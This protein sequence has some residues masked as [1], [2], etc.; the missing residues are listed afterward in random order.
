MLDSNVKINSK[1]RYKEYKAADTI[2]YSV[3][4][5][6]KSVFRSLLT[7]RSFRFS[8]VLRRYE[9]IHNCKK[10]IFA[11]L[12]E[13][14]VTLYFRH[15]SVKLCYNVPINVLGPGCCLHAYGPILINRGASVGDNTRIHVGVHLG[16]GAGHA[17]EAPKI[18]ANCYLGPGVK[19]FGNITILDGTAVG[20]NAVVNKGCEKPNVLLVGIPAVVKKEGIDTSDYVVPATI[21]AK[22][23]KA[24]QIKLHHKSASEVCAYLRENGYLPQK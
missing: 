18:G 5:T 20:A 6:F 9:Y 1:A 2:A 11:R 3:C 12:E 24:E 17:N 14:I 7:N 22:L 19:M 16:T 15:L 8:R 23:S 10:G 13:L 4:P 21:V